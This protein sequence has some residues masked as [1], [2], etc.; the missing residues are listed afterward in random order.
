MPGTKKTVSDVFLIG[1]GLVTAVPLLTFAKAAQSIPLI[2][3]GLMQYIAPTGQFLIGVLLYKEEFT[4]SQ[5]IGFV[6]I[7]IALIFF[8]LEGWLTSRRKTKKESQS[9][10]SVV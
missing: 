2:M 10:I 6:V 3:I 7:W 1:A 9:E 4:A 5:A 8:W